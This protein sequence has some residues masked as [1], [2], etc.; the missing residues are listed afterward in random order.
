MKVKVIAPVQV[1][2]AGKRHTHSDTAE[3]PNHIA[4]EWIRQGW[5]QEVKA[6]ATLAKAAPRKAKPG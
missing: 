5:A 2:H 6:G 3:V 4:A 1:V